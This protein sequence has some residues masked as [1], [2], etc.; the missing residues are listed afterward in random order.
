M[1]NRDQKIDSEINPNSV[2]LRTEEINSVINAFKTSTF[3]TDELYVKDNKKFVKKSLYDLAI[4]AEKKTNEIDQIDNLSEKQNNLTK[5]NEKIDQEITVSKETENFE[6]LDNVRINTPTETTEENKYNE[7]KKNNEDNK[8]NV[9]SE[10]NNEKLDKLE[11]DDGKQT[12]DNNDKIENNLNTEINKI[13]KN[14]SL[15]SDENNNQNPINDEEQDNKTQEALESVRDAVSKSL[16]KKQDFHESLD[17]Q[18][19]ERAIHGTRTSNEIDEKLDNKLDSINNLLTKIDD[20]IKDELRSFIIEKIIS[21]TS[22]VVGY[23][24]DKL[25]KKFID[26][27]NLILEELSIEKNKIFIFLNQQDLNSLQ[28]IKV[29]SIFNDNITLK[30]REKLNRGELILETNGIRKFISYNPEL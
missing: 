15:L 19:D 3:N 8:I 6:S 1:N 12:E 29:E 13:Q 4:E 16:E 30:A 10:P 18:E 7:T 21:L 28:K 17:N 9:S 27:I 22:D 11:N 23:Q 14:D 26:K 2:P 25:P 20:T 24:V 5:T